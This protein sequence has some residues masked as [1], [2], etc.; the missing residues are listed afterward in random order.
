[1]QNAW[2]SIRTVEGGDRRKKLRAET[3]ARLPDDLVWVVPNTNAIVAC[4]WTA[5]S[6][7]CVD[8]WRAQRLEKL[9]SNVAL[10]GLLDC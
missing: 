5:L 7:L 1:M 9:C 2:Q 6:T 3:E 10:A 8:E 4:V